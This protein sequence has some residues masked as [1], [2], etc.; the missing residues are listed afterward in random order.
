MSTKHLQR[1]SFF[2]KAKTFIISGEITMTRILSQFVFSRAATGPVETKVA[3]EQAC[4]TSFVSLCKQTFKTVWWTAR[5]HLRSDLTGRISKPPKTF[6]TKSVRR[7]PEHDQVAVR[8]AM[9][10]ERAD[11]KVCES[12][13]EHLD[14]E[15]A[16]KY[17]CHHRP[18]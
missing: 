1:H 13:C 11:I 3:T 9:R 17:Q 7:W 14:S 4:G 18:S 6:H 2:R 8:R 12:A 10:T 15:F 5:V 16:N